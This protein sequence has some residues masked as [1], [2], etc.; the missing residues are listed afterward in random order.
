MRTIPGLTV[1]NPGGAFYLFH[2]IRGICEKLDIIGRYQSLKPGV[3][4]RTS[5]S[6]LFQLF[7]LYNYRVGILDRK[8][9]GQIGSEG[10]HFV[11]ISLASEREQLK[12][13]VE[14]LRQAATDEQGFCKFFAKGEN[15]V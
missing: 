10:K 6:T 7:M 9:F 13:G 5:P 14:R 12:Q 4:E 15:L 1:S 11:R 3:R 8:S 2:N